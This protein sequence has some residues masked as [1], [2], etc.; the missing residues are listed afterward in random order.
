V[1]AGTAIVSMAMFMAAL[2][3]FGVVRVA[4]NAVR[5]TEN[6]VGTMRDGALNDLER[7]KT[8]QQASLRLL[9]AVGSLVIRIALAGAVASAPIWLASMSG[10]AAADGVVSYLTGWEAALIATALAA[11]AYGVRMRPWRAS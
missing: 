3:W 4:R 2:W 1:I 11:V 10:L 9:A 8:I 7:E 6:A 5:T